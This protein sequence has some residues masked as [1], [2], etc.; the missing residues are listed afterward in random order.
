M[1]RSSN[2]F[3]EKKDNSDSDDAE[4]LNEDH[5]S[6]PKTNPK[7]T[8]GFFSFFRGPATATASL[9]ETLTHSLYETFN[10]FSSRLVS[11]SVSSGHLT[12]GEFLKAGDFLV[13]LDESWEWA[14]S[15]DK[16][17]PEFPPD[18]QYLVNRGVPCLPNVNLKERVHL[19]VLQNELWTLPENLDVSQVADHFYDVSV[20]YDASNRTPRIWL[21]GYNKDGQPLK[22]EAI[23]QDMSVELVGK[24]TSLIAHPVTGVL[25][26]S[27]HPCRHADVMVRLMEERAAGN[28]EVY[29]VLFVQLISN[30]FPKLLLQ[31]PSL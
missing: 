17:L 3:L 7:S 2:P 16:M 28:R 23:I 13:K 11:G 29:L 31:V 19:D 26:V 30:V 24:V 18:R 9:D 20:T 12:K 4:V 5:I 8:G 21:I 27:I 10:A 1:K 25:N 15:L 14:F 6:P 22:P